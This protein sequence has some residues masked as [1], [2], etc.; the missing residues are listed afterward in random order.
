MSDGAPGRNDGSGTEFVTSEPEEAE[1][2]F[3]ISENEESGTEIED[4][5]M[6]IEATASSSRAIAPQ[7]P[8]APKEHFDPKTPMVLR[9]KKSNKA[10]KGKAK[11]VPGS[12]KT[13]TK[14]SEKKTG[15]ITAIPD[16]Q[17]SDAGS[18]DS[19]DVLVSGQSSGER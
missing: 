9:A 18:D 14:P 6:E 2:E 7:R 16:R 19:M 13:P 4:S 10:G 17:E 8:K 3:E 15:H 1:T 11:A 5:E 12:S